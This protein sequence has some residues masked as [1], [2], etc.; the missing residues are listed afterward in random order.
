[1]LSKQSV[2]KITTQKAEVKAEMPQLAQF[3]LP[4]ASVFSVSFVCLSAEEPKASVL[5]RC[6]G[7][8]VP[9]EAVRR[10]AGMTV[11]WKAPE[12]LGQGPVGQ[13]LS[14]CQWLGKL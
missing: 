13:P 6:P 4:L 8:G 1:M 3:S 11:A 9:R 14:P 10:E 5:A 2:G 7:L 12:P